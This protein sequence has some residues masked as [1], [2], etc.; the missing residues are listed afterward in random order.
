MGV[1]SPP[2]GRGRGWVSVPLP[3]G[4]GGGGSYAPN[5]ALIC[6]PRAAPGELDAAGIRPRRGQKNDSPPLVNGKGSERNNNSFAHSGRM[7]IA[8]YPQGVALFLA[9]LSPL[10]FES[11]QARAQAVFTPTVYT[12]L[13]WGKATGRRA[14]LGNGV[15]GGYRV[16]SSFCQ[17]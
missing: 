11:E 14:S 9:F 12:P 4:G 2:L 6:Q 3:W 17:K 5:G 10:C 16:L 1:S 15:G 8:N 13:P 7:L